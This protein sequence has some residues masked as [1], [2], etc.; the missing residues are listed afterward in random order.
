M[1]QV[2]GPASPPPASRL[3]LELLAALEPLEVPEL[4]ELMTVV[5][6]PLLVVLDDA[7]LV[8]MEVLS[9]PLLEAPAAVLATLD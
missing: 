2:S 3:P 7:V 5:A 8:V 9:A 1:A 6:L 4:L